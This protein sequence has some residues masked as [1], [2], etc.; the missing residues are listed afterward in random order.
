M[1][2]AKICIFAF[3]KNYCILQIQFSA[4]LAQKQGQAV[5]MLP[6]KECTPVAA[7]KIE[8]RDVKQPFL[9]NVGQVTE[10][11]NVAEISRV[12]RSQ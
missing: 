1:D 2:L 10:I 9:K 7:H 6:S 8:I 11:E 3:C 4:F 12:E 5:A